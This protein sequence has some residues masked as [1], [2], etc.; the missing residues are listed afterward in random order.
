[1]PVILD[2]YFNQRIMQKFSNYSVKFQWF[3]SQVLELWKICKIISR[4]FQSS[5]APDKLHVSLATLFSKMWMSKWKEN[6][7]L[8]CTLVLQ[9]PS[10][11][12][13]LSPPTWKWV[14]CMKKEQKEPDHLVLP[15]CFHLILIFW[16]AWKWW[17]DK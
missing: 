4:A 6:M 13:G 11:T 3:I 5:R 10:S 12:L 16:W 2:S 1:M 15:S 7:A 9:D 14:E 8:F 17:A